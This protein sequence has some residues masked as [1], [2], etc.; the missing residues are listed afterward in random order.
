[1]SQG[2]IYREL[3]CVF[4]IF[5]NLIKLDDELERRLKDLSIEKKIN[6]IG[7]TC[8]EKSKSEVRERENDRSF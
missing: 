2:L 8:M 7:S 1:M 3:R 4:E 6:Q 5:Y